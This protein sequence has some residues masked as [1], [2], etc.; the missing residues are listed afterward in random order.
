MQIIDAGADV[1]LA[2]KRGM[3][4]LMIAAKLGND[5]LL[6]YLISHQATIN[7]ADENG[8]TAW[9]FAELYNQTTCARILIEHNAQR[10]ISKGYVYRKS[11]RDFFSA[12]RAGKLELIKPFLKAHPEFFNAR[13]EN[14]DHISVLAVKNKQVTILQYLK[15]QGTP[16]RNELLVYALENKAEDCFNFLLHELRVPLKQAQFEIEG[17][18]LVYIATFYN[19]PKC[20]GK[21]IQAGA[22]VSACFDNFSPLFNATEGNHVDCFLILMRAGADM[23]F[24]AQPE[25]IS[26]VY[27]AIDKG[28]DDCLQ[29][30]ANH[31]A[32]LNELSNG[33]VPPIALAAMLGRTTSLAILLK[34][35]ANQNVRYSGY[36]PAH[37]AVQNNHLDCLKLLYQAGFDISQT[38]EYNETIMQLAAKNP[39]SPCYAFLK[40]LT[41]VGTSSPVNHQNSVFSSQRGAVSDR[42]PLA[43]PPPRP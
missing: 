35:G 33:D 17:A 37:L 18:P 4:P 21:L 39:Q 6:H 24:K 23:R 11:E 41:K 8:M 15:E 29:L 25:G 7:A 34:A 19:M 10:N 32:D 20:L 36:F 42:D 26:L 22:N 27:H 5:R 13:D 1:N 31:G 40:T 38:N 12:V 14:G 9:Q 43:P 16:F 28:S 30:L 2:D 3:T